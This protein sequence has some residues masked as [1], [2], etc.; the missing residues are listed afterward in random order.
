MILEGVP[1]FIS[2][3][4]FFRRLTRFLPGF[5]PGDYVLLTANS[6]IG[7]S[8]FARFLFIKIPIILQAKNPKFK[9]KIFLNSLEE[10]IEK[11]ESTFIS[12]YIYRKH[13]IKL[14]Y[15]KL[16]HFSEEALPEHTMNCIREAEEFYDNN[17]RPYLEVVIDPN[18]EDFYKRVLRYMA[19]HGK[20]YN[21]QG[22]EVDGLVKHFVKYIP[23]DPGRF[24]IV[25]SDTINNY[26]AMP[27]KSWYE[28][29]KMFSTKYCRQQ[30][31]LKCKCIVVNLQQQASD[32]EKV[33]MNKMGV[34][35]EQKLEPSLDGLGDI[36]ITQRDATVALGLFHPARYQI[37][38]HG[39]W[40]IK[41]MFG[42]Y[43]A[44]SIL[45]T[46][47][48]E[49]SEHNQLAIEIQHGDHFQELPTD[50]RGKIIMYNKL[51]MENKF[52]S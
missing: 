1:T 48:G 5:M 49:M 10:S 27:G 6:G 36:K 19:Q 43:R 31:C 8:R 44:L 9:V 32:K 7:K 12:S 39:G 14:D 47:E 33:E 2:I 52:V 50:D 18:P 38:S 37:G 51:E 11:V 3:A 30:L 24:V 34:P 20:F 22:D 25:I 13:N 42:K 35:I 15:Y 23:D 29:L 41:K 45:K 16:N 17:I 40:N 46:R 26:D 4:S 28:T 21:E